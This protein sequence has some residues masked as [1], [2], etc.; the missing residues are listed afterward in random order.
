MFSFVFTSAF[1]A[2]NRCTASFF[3][4]LDAMI[5]KFFSFLFITLH[6]TIRSH[7]P[8]FLFIIF[9]VIF[10]TIF[11]KSIYTGNRVDSFFRIKVI[12]FHFSSSN[13]TFPELF[14]CL[15]RYYNLF[16]TLSFLRASLHVKT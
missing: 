9:C 16:N 11:H 12:Y 3:P 14:L 7:F 6:A 10:H 8:R 5:D 4:F 15:I 2:S 13:I 1:A